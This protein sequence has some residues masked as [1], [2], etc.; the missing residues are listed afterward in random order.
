MKKLRTVTTVITLLLLAA[1]VA[2]AGLFLRRC[3]PRPVQ[4]NLPAV[5][6]EDGGNLLAVTTLS[7][8][9]EFDPMPEEDGCSAVFAGRVSTPYVDF[10][11]SDSVLDQAF[12]FL[13]GGTPFMGV[14]GYQSVPGMSVRGY[15]NLYCD[16]GLTRFAV[17]FTK[18]HAYSCWV[19]APAETR[20]EALPLLAALGLEEPFPPG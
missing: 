18:G 17:H 19:A 2:A 15:G 5:V 7:L 20:E 10:T 16:E 8:D 4:E 13:S 1:C 6:L 3:V 14:C 9:G 12:R 11:C